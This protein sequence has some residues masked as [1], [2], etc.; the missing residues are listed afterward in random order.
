MAFLDGAQAE[1]AVADMIRDLGYDYAY[2]P[3]IAV[4]GAQ[5]NGR[6]TIQAVFP[7]GKRR[8]IRLGE[9]TKK[10][11]EFM[12]TRIDALLTTKAMKQSPD[13]ET[14]KWVADIGD[15]LH[16][17][18]VAVG[19]VQP[20]Q[21]STLASFLDAYIKSRVDAK[22]STITFYGHTRRCLV[23]FFGPDKPLR[24]ITPGDADDWRLWLIGH[25]E[26]EDNTV[27]RRSDVAKQF[28]G[29]A[30]RKGLVP[31]NSFV[32][33]TGS[34]RSNPDRFFYV[35]R[36]MAGKVLKAC[37][38]GEWRLMFSLSR[39][40]GLR[41][42]SEYRELKWSDV[43]W[44]KG[45]MT[46]T[47]PKT[48]HNPGGKSRRVPL[49]PE[50]ERAL[51]D[52]FDPLPTGGSIYIVPRCRTEKETNLR[53]HM[54]TIIER[55]GLEPWPKV[56][57]NMRS[58]RETELIAA[59]FPE[60]VVLKWLGHTKAV[61]S[62]FYLQVTDDDYRRGAGRP[63]Q[64]AVQQGAADPCTDLQDDQQED[65]ETAFCGSPQGPADA[66]NSFNNK[67]MGDTGLEPVTPCV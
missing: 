47:S 62:K 15:D 21:S 18:L 41:C 16:A 53:K 33:L 22:P 27:R 52:V 48:E 12:Q 28:F 63:V 43:D 19:L 36:E 55:A 37:P 59:G 25:E 13:M 17:K 31:L 39:F 2:G 42:T 29:S 65:H 57:Q 49:F 5:P 45:W 4:D 24:D 56:F 34:V 58:T 23:E 7:D 60:H 54:T 3:D 6:R 40:G 64:N 44:D 26:L 10:Q 8:S 61:A 66:C 35:T 30:L 1:L 38:D 67:D 32:H 50:L 11:A 14:A 20:R 9:V 46:V 51:R